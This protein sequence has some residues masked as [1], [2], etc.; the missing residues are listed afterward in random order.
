M[1]QLSTLEVYER[2]APSYLAEP[3]NPL[4]AAEQVAMLARLPELA[5]RVVLDLACGTG[6]YAQLALR[7]GAARVVALDNCAAMLARVASHERV[8]ADMTRLPFRDASFDVVVSG[9]ALGHA[10]DLTRCMTEIARVLRPG[11][12]L[13]YSDFHHEAGRRG[14]ERSFR[15]GGGTRHTLPADGYDVGQ[16]RDALRSAGL[17]DIELHDIRAGHELNGSFP[18]A[19]EFYREWHGT[20]MVLV[21]RARRAM[22]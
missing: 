17:L 13:Q 16:H 21:A 11:G 2:W 3:H 19:E 6:R 18:G 12:V 20:P 9:L 5:G 15:D 10:S 7:A 4:M 1:S 14:L 22:S 8:R